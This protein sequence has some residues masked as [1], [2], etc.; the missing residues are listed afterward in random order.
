MYKTPA[1]RIRVGDVLYELVET[2]APTAGGTRLKSMHRAEDDAEDIT[3]FSQLNAGDKPSLYIIRKY[4]LQLS[5][6]VEKLK[7]AY[8]KGEIDPWISVLEEIERLSRTVNSAAKDEL[9]LLK[10]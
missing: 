9:R 1:K 10:S 5:D 4:M 8:S 3:Q 2:E 7:D 6:Q